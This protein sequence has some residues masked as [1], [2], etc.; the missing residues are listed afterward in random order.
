MK[1]KLKPGQLVEHKA[2]DHLN[3]L[4]YI[5]FSFFKCKKAQE[6]LDRVQM[7]IERKENDLI[8]QNNN[9]DNYYEQIKYRKH[10]GPKTIH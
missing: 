1:L 10:R 9:G 5:R 7:L 8:N 6:V 3:N 4:Y 2:D